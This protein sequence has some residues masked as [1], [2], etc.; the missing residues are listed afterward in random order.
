M[1]RSFSCASTQ[2]LFEGRTVA[3][4]ADIERQARRQL[5]RLQ[6]AGRFSSL[7][8]GTGSAVPEL[9]EPNCPPFRLAIN[10][11]WTLCFEWRPEGAYGV[12]IVASTRDR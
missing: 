8:I 10:D 3:K 12:A 4:F 5:L 7:W 9:R 6:A 2:R 1:I 11:S